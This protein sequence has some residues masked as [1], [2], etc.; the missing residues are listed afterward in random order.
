ML[1]PKSTV[2]KNDEN[3]V[4]KVHNVK[5]VTT[6]TYKFV[7]V[8]S[9]S[10]SDAQITDENQPPHKDEVDHIAANCSFTGIR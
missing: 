1:Q 6:E 2:L 4:P 8:T 10:T 7:S 3:A 9:H 5:T